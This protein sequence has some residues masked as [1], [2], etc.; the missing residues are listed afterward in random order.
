MSRARCTTRCAPDGTYDA[1]RPQPRGKSYEGRF[2]KDPALAEELIEDLRERG[3][4]LRVEDYEHSYPHCWRSGN[5]LIYYAKPSWYIATSRVREEL[6]AANE[7]RRLAPAARQARALRRLAG[8][9]RRLGALARALLGHAAAG[10]ALRA[11]PHARDRLLRR[12]RRA[13]P[14][15]AR[16]PSP[17]VRRRRRVPLPAR[18][19]GL[20]GELF[21][22]R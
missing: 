1:A 14:A 5:P 20:G 9:Q 10:V 4:L 13:L 6:L 17:P 22:C 11:G 3:L 19:R 7:T 2:V 18:R 16:R 12:A 15:H 8:E 21:G